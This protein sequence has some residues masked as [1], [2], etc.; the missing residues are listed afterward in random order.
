M[1]TSKMSHTMNN[2]RNEKRAD[3]GVG[4]TGASA[5]ERKITAHL[6]EQGELST[7]D[8]GGNIRGQTAMCSNP[9]TLAAA[10]CLRRMEKR[11]IVQ[12]RFV[13]G[14]GWGRTMWRLSPNTTLSHAGT[15]A[16]KQDGAATGV[17]SGNS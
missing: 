6:A 4:S 1:L 8:L 13:S 3:N 16:H 5:L 15:S 9:G 12:S 7:A 14:K 2:D 17:G 11:G 10:A